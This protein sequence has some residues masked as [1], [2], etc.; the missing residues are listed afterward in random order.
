MLDTQWFH[1]IPFKLYFKM[2]GKEIFNSVGKEFRRVGYTSQNRK[3]SSI[4]AS[5]A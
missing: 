3:L 2:V 1:K 5:V 4:S